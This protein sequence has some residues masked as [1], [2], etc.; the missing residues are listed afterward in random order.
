[1]RHSSTDVIARDEFA[2]R[3]LVG[4]AL[5]GLASGLVVAA[6]GWGWA[7]ALLAIGP[8]LGI[9]AMARLRSEPEA[10]RLAGG[11]R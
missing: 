3:L 1:M 11:R 8:A 9:L 2:R 7:F 5:A 4:V 6:F 10:L